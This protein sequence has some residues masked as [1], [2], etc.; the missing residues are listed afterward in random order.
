[1]EKISKTHMVRGIRQGTERRFTHYHRCYSD[2]L[3]KCLSG[4]TNHVTFAA[5]EFKVMLMSTHARQDVLLA[6]K[7]KTAK[8]TKSKKTATATLR[9]LGITDKKGKIT[10]EYSCNPHVKAAIGANVG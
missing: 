2:A 9:R 10:N 6:I 5:A 4:M 7:K 8:N 1:M 3:T